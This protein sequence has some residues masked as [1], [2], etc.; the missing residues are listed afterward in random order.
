MNMQFISLTKF[1]KNL[2]SHAKICFMFSF[3]DKLNIKM[4]SEYHYLNQSNCLVIDD[5]DDARKFH[6]LMVTKI[7]VL[8]TLKDNLFFFLVF[9]LPISFM[10]PKCHFFGLFLYFT[11]EPQIL[12]KFAKKIKSMHF[13]CLL[14]CYGWETYHFKQL[15]VKIMWRWL[16]MK[17]SSLYLVL[18][19][20]FVMDALH[21]VFLRYLISSF[22]L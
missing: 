12:F 17:V 5:V 11:R 2:L 6:V 7:Q 8:Q 10:Y 14:Q 20:T 21:L 18:H 22:Q 16:L 19:A 4:A 15:T 3:T 1:V 13:Q 9:L